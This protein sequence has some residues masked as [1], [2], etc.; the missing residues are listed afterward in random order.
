MEGSYSQV[1]EPW[2]DFYTLAGTAAATLMGLLFVAV[3][4]RPKIMADGGPEGLRA[5]AGQTMSNL[6]ALLIVS[7]VCM[8]PDLDAVTFATAVIVL[9]AQGLARG[10]WR[11]RAIA[12]DPDP[13]WTLAN[14][15]WRGVLPVAAYAIA[16]WVGLDILRGPPDALEW[17]VVVA[18]LLVSASAGAAWSL[19]IEMGQRDEQGELDAGG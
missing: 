16:I 13:T 8:M 7:L 1:L 4:L 6:I 18:F 10:A 12:R 17:L 11:L 5:W 15:V 3:S 19:L 2:R 9:G 14:V